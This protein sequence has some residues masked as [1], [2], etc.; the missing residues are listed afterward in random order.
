MRERLFELL[1][2]PT[3]SEVATFTDGAAVRSRFVRFHWESTGSRW[4]PYT[5]G[6]GYARWVGREYFVFDWEPN[7]KRFTRWLLDHYPADKLS[8]LLKP[9][10]RDVQW[11]T[12]TDVANGSMA[13]R[14]TERGF[15]IGHKGPAV[16]SEI[17]PLE[18]LLG[19][20]N[21]RLISTLLRA[22]NPTLSF[23]YRDLM[24]APYVVGEA[25]MRAVVG[26]A[27]ALKRLTV[28]RDPIERSFAVLDGS[29]QHSIVDDILDD[30]AQSEARSVRLNTLEAASEQLIF[31]QF[32]IEGDDLVSILDETG[33]PCGWFPLISGY[34]TSFDGMSLNSEVRNLDHSG[35]SALRR[36]LGALY[37]AGPGAREVEDVDCEPA[38]D[39]EMTNH[40]VGGSLPI[41]T[42]SFLEELSQKLQI[43][44]LS[45]YRLLAEMKTD[46]GLIC[47]PEIR[48]LM[49]E[50][51]SITIL[52][53]LGHLWPTEVES[54]TSSPTWF[55]PE[56]LATLADGHPNQEI[57]RNLVKRMTATFGASSVG[58]FQKL[59]DISL[60]KW[61]KREFY[62][63]HVRQFRSRPVV[64]QVQTQA[65]SS[66]EDPI[67]SCFLYYH[68][69]AGAVPNLRTQYAGTLRTSFESELRTLEVLTQ[70]TVDQSGRKKKL[71]FWIEELKEFQDAL[72][73]IEVRGFFTPELQRYAI[74]DAIHSLTRCWL[75]RLREVLRK[76]PLPAWQEK[77]EREDL[78]P[79]FSSWIAEAVEHVD[80][81]CVAVAPDPP[82]LDIAD[83][84]LTP[85]ALSE[86]FRSRAPSM[87]RTALEAICREWQ[88]QFDKTLVKPLR[89]LIKAAE[90]EHKELE[91]NIENKLLRK[92]L[93]SKVKVLKSEIAT[94]AAKSGALADEICDWR[95]PK[96]E[97]WVEWLA[98][99]PLYDE[100]ASHD[101]RRSV[102]KTVADFVSQESQYAPDI[103][104][105]V[106]VNIAPLQKAGILAR[107][108]LAAK[109]VDKAIADRAEW[110]AD[111]R[112][113]CRQGVLPRPGWWPEVRVSATDAQDTV[114]STAGI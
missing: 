81:Q 52:R 102:P 3:L 12:W 111:E 76:V 43:H 59:L 54:G 51:V 2:G 89:E 63:R 79:E 71:G 60:D 25:S 50:R 13:G 99:Q 32:G 18:I 75:A 109:D 94:L 23:L 105:G 37:A 67:F 103:N 11:I 70:P 30:I 86:S 16:T 74:V 106:R 27:L 14:L 87:I 114:S 19:L 62:A 31:S 48:R 101:G 1:S 39:E 90:E 91:D 112:R 85:A 17:V 42:E 82:G 40:L 64:W 104:D 66:G 26:E 73:S 8:L 9:H 45:T 56:G 113:W 35:L 5:K 84:K 65:S 33:T 36:R 69:I 92:S 15:L 55:M 77:T 44:P 6:G 20:M 34:I 61:V 96:A 68:R 29:K 47:L 41:P 83:E 57:M 24:R 49:E 97:E 95:F 100:F 58:E 88:S 107:D 38:D 4:T 10:R 46:E 7:G 108:V 72:E 78:H 110:R 28:A 80:R 98:T 22:I 93:K 53:L 21:S